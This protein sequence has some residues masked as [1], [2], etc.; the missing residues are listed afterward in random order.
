MLLQVTEFPFFYSFFGGL[1]IYTHTYVHT[2]HTHSTFLSFLFF[3]FFLPSSMACRSSWARESNLSHSSNNAEFLTA[4]PVGNLAT[5]ILLFF[6]YPLMELHMIPC[7]GYSEL[8]CS[9]HGVQ[10]SPSR[11][12][13]PLDIYS[14]MGFMDGSSIFKFLRKLRIVSHSYYINIHTYQ[15]CIWYLISPYPDQHLL[16]I[17]FLY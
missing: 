10:V 11:E 1:N 12:W 4:R 2:P 5:Y 6:I 17:V 14:E 13:F 9:E 8:Y 3:F 7:L 15:Q 16:S